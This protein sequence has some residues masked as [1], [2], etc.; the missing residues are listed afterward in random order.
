M[1]AVPTS[2]LFERLRQATLGRY[3]IYAELGQGGMATVFLALDLALDR[4]VAIKVLDP[5]L[6]TSPENIERF[7]REAK[8]AASLSHPN[9]IGI[10]AVGDDPELA[11]FVMKYIEGRALDSVVRES[12]AQ[13]VAFV[14]GVVVAAGKALHYAHTRGVVHRDVK[15]ANFMLDKEG[16]LIV[17]DFGIAKRDD[18]H[19]LT[20][21]GSIIGTPYYMAP[22]QFQGLPITAAADQYALGVVAFELLTG[23]QPYSGATIGEVM[24]GHLFDPIPDVKALRPDV[25]EQIQAAI[26]KMLAKEP[27]DRFATLEEAVLA[28]GHVTATQEQE[29][30][31]QIVHLA[32]SGAMLQPQISVPISP[33]PAVRPRS[34]AAVPPQGSAP[35]GAVPQGSAP[36]PIAEHPAHTPP[37]AGSAPVSHRRRT[38]VLIALGLIVGVAGATAM[39]RPD[40]VNRY[41]K[42]LLGPTGDAADTGAV[43]RSQTG[44]GAPEDIGVSRGSRSGA[45]DASTPSAASGV[46]GGAPLTPEELDAIQR[47][48]AQ[49][50]RDSIARADSLQRADSIARADSIRRAA[51]ALGGAAASGLRQPTPTRRQIIRD[52]IAALRAAAMRAGAAGNTDTAVAA[53]QPPQTIPQ[54]FVY[55]TVLIGSRCPSAVL[56]VDGAAERPIGQR[57][58]QELRQ[59][60]G[61]VTLRVRTL[62]GARWDT[63]F[64]VTA[65]REHR[66]GFRPL[67]C[68]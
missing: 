66:I 18:A 46:E 42:Q 53:T 41:R 15:P 45:A 39:L 54:S 65:G 2:Q 67:R 35:A 55:G 22:E 64:T 17:T 32:Q 12:G 63:T 49:A 50:V 59:V 68:Q 36:R 44:Q 34:E 16:W 61:S 40:I 62:S 8:V 13:S 19:G 43:T 57:G 14:K 51:A 25:P 56:Y 9:I 23:R 26:T 7:R 47:A 37:A 52:S 58:I 60:A 30:R 3:D 31:T 10:H 6:A 5:S 38:W 33:V 24:K 21:T 4:K 29:I 1:S 11:Y 28:F 20:M 27:A 48:A